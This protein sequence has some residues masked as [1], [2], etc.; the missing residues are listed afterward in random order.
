MNV[1]LKDV[2]EAAGVSVSTVSRVINGDRERPASA[3]TTEKIWAIVKELGYIPNQSAKNLVKGEGTRQ[4][5]KGSIGCIYTSTIDVKTDP[6]FSCIGIGIQQTLREKGYE[7]AYALSTYNMDFSKIYNHIVNHP[8]EGIIV[9][10]R[11]ENDIL[12]LIK[13]QSNHIVYAGVNAVNAGFDEVLCDGYTGAKTA[14]RHLLERGH[15]SIGYVGYLHD[16]DKEGALVNEHRYSAYLDFMK[17]QNL[18]VDERWVVHTRLRTTGAYEAMNDYLQKIDQSAMPSCFYCAND[19][20]AFGV[21]KALQVHGIKIPEEVA[22]IGLDNVEMAQFVT[23]TL[24]SVSIPRKSLGIQAVQLLVD[25]I[26]HDRK[27][28]LRVDLP[29]ELVVRESSNYDRTEVL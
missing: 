8:T 5:G 13:K 3:G 20:T 7:M 25:Q 26:E 12:D 9:T 29:F 11:F 18:T 21:M 10:G 16:Q 2:A 28:P 27:Y 6:F 4:E 14:L 17:E 23:P 19:A 1:K 22:I 15:R 24:S